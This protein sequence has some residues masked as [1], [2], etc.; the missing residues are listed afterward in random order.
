MLDERDPLVGIAIREERL[1]LRG[2]R[3][4]SPGIEVRAPREQRIGDE[5][6]FPGASAFQVG[7]DMA[8]E[9]R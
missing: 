6:R 8:V 2:R 9:R 1:Q 3:R 7:R 4:Q 5:H